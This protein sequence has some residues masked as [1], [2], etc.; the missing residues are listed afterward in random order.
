[1]VQIIRNLVSKPK[2][3]SVQPKP[4]V[5]NNYERLCY[6]ARNSID[7]SSF[8]HLVNPRGSHKVSRFVAALLRSAA[9]AA[10]LVMNIF[11][12]LLRR[13]LGEMNSHKGSIEKNTCVSVPMLLIFRPQGLNNVNPGLINHGL[14]IRWYPPNSHNMVHI[15]GTL[16]I[17]Q[18]RGLLIQGWHY[19]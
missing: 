12:R 17:K 3:L 2:N 13:K 9:N 4:F 8:Q 14:L 7:I 11:S 16:R 19:P 6:R 15:N 1:M 10:A 5:G 18:P